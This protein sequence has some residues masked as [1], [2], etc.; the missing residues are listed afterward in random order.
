MR[1]DLQTPTT[2]LPQTVSSAVSRLKQRL[3]QHYERAYPDLRQIIHLV[4]DEE[5]MQAWKLS[6]F[7][8]LFLPD[9][10]E[11]HFDRLNLHS[12]ETKHSKA[13]MQPRFNSITGLHQSTVAF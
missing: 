6:D 3:Q 10:V 11:A 12:A 13:T 9:L 5:E 2:V 1:T 8:Q 4:L 7:P